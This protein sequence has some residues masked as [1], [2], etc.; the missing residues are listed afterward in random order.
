MSEFRT[1]RCV[2][3]MSGTLR[4][5]CGVEHEF[6]LQWAED[7][8]QDEI[9]DQVLA[10]SGWSETG[11]CPKCEDETQREEAG[12]RAMREAKSS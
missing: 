11:C 9:E 6:D 7:L 10:D 4:C 3:S 2:G 5:T 1:I 12:D 8:G